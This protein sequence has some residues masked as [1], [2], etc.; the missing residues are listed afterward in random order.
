MYIDIVGVLRELHRIFGF[1][2]ELC[3]EQVHLFI[4]VIQSPYPKGEKERIVFI[5][6]FHDFF[7]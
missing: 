7:C 3:F 6:N 2:G 5:L 1:F 4:E